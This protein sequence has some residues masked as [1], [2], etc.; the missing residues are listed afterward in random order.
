[1]LT[2]RR[3]FES[4][5]HTV[6]SLGDWSL[7]FILWLPEIMISGDNRT[8]YLFKK[9]TFFVAKNSITLVF[10]SDKKHI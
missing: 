5:N 1:M 8:F 9:L 7:Q 2:D 6:Q 10:I 4:V 3:N